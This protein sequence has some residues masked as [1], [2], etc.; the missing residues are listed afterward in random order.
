[1]NARSP[2]ISVA[3]AVSLSLGCAGG[4]GSAPEPAAQPA[5]V[6]VVVPAT[7]TS[8]AGTAAVEEESG[9]SDASADASMGAL[10]TMWGESIGEA[11][12]A[13]GLGLTGIGPGGGG[14]GEGIGLGSIGTLGHGAG[15]G[16]G[17]GAG[18]GYGRLG[19]SRP[20]QN[21]PTVT[22]EATVVTGALD[23]DIIRRV[24]RRHV[25]RFKFCY[26]REL[27]KSPNLQGKV[28]I[29]FVINREGSVTTTQDAGSTMPNASVVACVQRT[30]ASMQFPK[31]AGAGVVVVTYPLV[32]RST[33]PATPDAG[34]PVDA[35][36]DAGRD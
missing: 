3:L 8:D 18:S 6:A 5:T 10:G 2:R 15:A 7:A 21:R 23:K 33:D 30:F 1:M 11:F 14:T 13:G 4:Q 19:G 27:A 24:I 34:T 26:E 35:A 28:V 32:F 31:P 22:T 20:P 36:A 17:S 25:N 16:T 9:D 12:G 29:R